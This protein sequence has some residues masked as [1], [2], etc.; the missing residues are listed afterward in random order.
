MKK[1][2]HQELVSTSSSEVQIYIKDNALQISLVTVR[3]KFVKI[4]ILLNT[5]VNFRALIVKIFQNI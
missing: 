2:L 3:K 1:T 4:S 5:M